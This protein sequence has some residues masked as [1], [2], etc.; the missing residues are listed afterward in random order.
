MNAETFAG[1]AEHKFAGLNLDAVAADGTFSGYA[2]LFGA[3]DLAKDV[4]EAG[5]FA[6]SI[7]ARG[8]AGIRML[9]QHDPG[10]PIGTW[11]EVREDSRGLF[12]RGRLATDVAR[13]REVLALMR[14]GALDG[15]SIGFRAVRASRDAGTGIRRIREADLWEISVVTFP[16]LPGARVE[17]V[18]G[19]RRLPTVREFETWLRRDAGL[20]RGEAKAVI[21]DGYASLLRARDAAPGSLTGLAERI[22]AAISTINR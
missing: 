8:A 3:V 17:T 10:E 14:G 1:R 20:T 12:V 6:R 11:S 15:L 7:A 19:R 2:S 21:A 18:K 22:R 16:M 9:F 4:V 13:A 5:A